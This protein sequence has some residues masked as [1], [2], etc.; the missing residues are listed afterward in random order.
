MERRSAMKKL[1]V[2]LSVVLLTV[3][4]LLWAAGSK[5]EAAA[6]ERGKYLAERGKIVPPEE[7]YID[8]Y[9]AHINYQYPKPETDFGVTLYSG[10]HQVSSRG[11]E[12]II[13]IGIQGKELNFEDLPPM[14]LAFV[15]DKSGSM[16]DR[17]K[18]DWVK[19]S[20]YIFI[21][22]VRDKD[23]VALIYFDSNARTVFSST[24]MD[25]SVNRQKFR[26]HVYRVE[27]GGG[28]NLIDGV[29]LGYKEVLT[30]Y[31]SEYINRVLVLSDG[32][33]STSTY[34]L[35][36]MAESYRD[37]GINIST[38][39]LGEDFDLALMRNLAHVGGG[40]SRFISDREE[41]EETFGSEL[42]RMV[43]PI[44]N[45]VEMNLEFL[46]D[47]RILDTWGYDNRIIGN[48][49]NY[50]LSTLHHRDYET[51][52]V[53]IRIPPL[54]LDGK[55]TL[56]RF[57][58]KY[59]DL[60]GNTCYKGPYYLRITFVDMEYP[61]TGFSDGM[62][63]RSGTML[64]FAQALQK[65][66]ESYYRGYQG[67]EVQN[68]L[69]LT[70]ETRKELLNAR[71]RLDY[72]GFDDEIGIL[73]N[74]L[75]IFS[76]ELYKT[77]GETRRIVEDVEIVPPVRER[78]L[79]EHMKN[80]YR[81]ITLDLVAKGEGAIAI[82]GFTMKDGKSSELT[83]LLDE[84][85]MLE[86]T[87]LGTLRVIER[88][89]MDMILEEQALSLSDLMDTSKAID[90]GKLLTA[91]HI[92]TGTVIEMPNSVVIFGRVINVE[93]AE[94]ESAAQVIVPKNRE[95]KSLL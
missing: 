35:M 26:D 91:N 48:R 62:V 37:M 93:T 56:A 82:S 66:G 52:L 68:A 78:S 34:G 16:A 81:E 29:R 65:I 49:I 92:L 38:I 24:K 76:G 2:V 70:V 33:A 42:D 79:H 43:V 84:M 3:P 61:V 50:Y 28:T 1:H 41:M 40:S 7:V 64:H 30:N 18:M 85:A 72:M 47:V 77:E 46:Q 58:V 88:E 19:E 74:Y 20:F 53:Q 12:E 55:V 27:P 21:D 83:T 4:P 75:K 17:D 25:S 80:L 86:I 22:K 9:V 36:E 14:N 51:I 71:E 23:F 90:V 95:V 6:P 94:I 8:S 89:K 31:R 69:D 45:D 54:G 57:S 73:D 39:G 44:A 67:G 63:L 13:Q 87:Q 59:K 32:Q 11:Q 15:I 10:H 5:E 60:E